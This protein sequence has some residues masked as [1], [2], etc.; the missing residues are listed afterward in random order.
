MQHVSQVPDSSL[1]MKKTWT[2][3][4]VSWGVMASTLLHDGVETGRFRVRS[5][6]PWLTF[7]H[8]VRHC[9]AFSHPVRLCFTLLSSVMPARCLSTSSKKSS[10]PVIGWVPCVLS[11][12]T[13]HDDRPGRNIQ[14]PQSYLDSSLL[15]DRL[16]FSVCIRWTERTSFPTVRGSLAAKADELG[17][18][19]GLT[20]GSGISQG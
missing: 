12:G 18:R 3:S 2:D 8:R 6:L 1:W 15:A 20:F 14:S 5:Y 7:F 9:W 16:P 13:W 17:S 11:M 19:R 4:G 10:F